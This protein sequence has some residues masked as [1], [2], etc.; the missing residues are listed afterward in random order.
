MD[1]SFEGDLDRRLDVAGL[2][3][4][5]KATPSFLT[6]DARRTGARSLS[7]SDSESEYCTGTE[8]YYLRRVSSPP[9]RKHSTLT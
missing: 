8:S 9:L 1:E 5:G 3:S 2:A 7:A 6:F 4:T